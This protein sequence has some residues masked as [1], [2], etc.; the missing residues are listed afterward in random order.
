MTYINLIAATYYNIKQY[1]AVCDGSTNDASK[2]QDAI[3]AA[4]AAG[5]GTII[6]PGPTLINSQLTISNDN[7]QFIGVGHGAQIIA[8]SSFPINTPMLKVNAPGGAGNFRYGI[9]IADIFFNGNNRTGVGAI[10]LD[11]TYQAL[12]DHC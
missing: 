3:N 6:V 8:G 10:E 9:K 12:I 11:S 1:G 2:V 7:I 5:Q 4:Q